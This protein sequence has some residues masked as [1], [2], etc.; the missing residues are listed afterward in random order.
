MGVWTGGEDRKKWFREEQR[1][2]RL[3]EKA[4]AGFAPPHAPMP[5]ER[6]TLLARISCSPPNRF[7]LSAEF[8]IFF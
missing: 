4:A 5:C 2:S 7:I 6:P 8:G 3:G 1:A